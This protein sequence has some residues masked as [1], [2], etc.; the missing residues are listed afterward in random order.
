MTIFDT[1]FRSKLGLPLPTLLRFAYELGS[2]IDSFLRVPKN[3]KAE[4][5]KYYGL[6]SF[7]S[8]LIKATEQQ[9]K[10]KFKGMNAVIA[11]RHDF[12]G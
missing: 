2:V 8:T 7:L 10:P 3:N 9:V 12:L 5:S 1:Y 11:L 6:Q 4:N